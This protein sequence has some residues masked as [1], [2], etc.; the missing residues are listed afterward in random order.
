MKKIPN[1]VIFHRKVPWP[2]L[3]LALVLAGCGNKGSLV[4]PQEPPAQTQDDAGQGD[5]TGQTDQESTQKQ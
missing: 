2:G 5:A 4:L 1:T 3:L